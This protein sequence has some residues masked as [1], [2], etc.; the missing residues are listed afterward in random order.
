MCAERIPYISPEEY[1]VI[2]RAA[3][4]KSEYLDGQM[5]AMTGASFRHNR[6]IVNLATRLNAALRG[7]PCQ[8]VVQD[9]R[10]RVSPEGL[11][12]YPDVV[13]VCGEPEFADGHEDTLTN[14]TLLVEVLSPSTEAYDRGAKF[15]HYRT[16]ST[17]KQY[18][19]VA[20]EEPLVEVYTR[21]EGGGWLLREF[22]GLEAT[23][24]LTA[25]DCHVSLAEVYR[26]LTFGA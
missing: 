24:E 4:A 19:L 23:A 3:E 12:T 14:P 6:I 22:R 21:Q 16:L 10:V 25:I 8:V 15:R 11:C 7:G 9:L 26:D 2:E 18:V 5:F 20:Q 1:L 13:T 17:L